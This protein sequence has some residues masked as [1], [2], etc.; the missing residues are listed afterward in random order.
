MSQSKTEKIGSYVR[1][2]GYLSIRQKITMPRK[3]K[4]HLGKLETVG[5]S[6]EINLFH[7]KHKIGGPYN[8]HSAA[9]TEANEL[10]DKKF[11]YTKPK[12]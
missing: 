6:V 11:K 10:L 7:G 1:K 12:K 9:E 8:S 2:V 5:G 4:N 3:R